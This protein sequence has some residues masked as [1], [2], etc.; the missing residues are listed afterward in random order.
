VIAQ[1]LEDF[2]GVEHR[3]ELVTEIRGVRYVNDSKAT[4]TAAA[5]RA[6]AAYDDPLHVI[7]GGS[8]KGEDFESLA[9]AVSESESVRAV[10]LIGEAA[11]ELERALRVAAVPLERCGDLQTAVEC[12]A[13]KARAGEIVLLSPACASFDEFRDFEHRGEEFRRLVQNLK[14]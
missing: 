4:N 9:D 13:A 8:L 6:L 1:A 11:D 5:R 10:Y 3:L 14:G 7:L 12:A 2:P